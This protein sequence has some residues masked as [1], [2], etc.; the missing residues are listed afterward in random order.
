LHNTKSNIPPN[1]ILKEIHSKTECMNTQSKNYINDAVAI[2]KREIGIDG[3]VSIILFGS[4]LYL[5]ENQN[6]STKISDCD[7]LIIFKDDVSNNLIRKVDRYFVALEYKHNFRKENT[8]IVNKIASFINQTTG[9]F[10][11]HFNQKETL[12]KRYLSQ[13]IQ[14]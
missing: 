5:N 7:L 4:Q 3:I 1:N 13:N 8:N 6:E 9:M 11:S 10:V 2:I 14:R 12:G